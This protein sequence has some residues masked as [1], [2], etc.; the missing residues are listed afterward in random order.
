MAE[1]G[2]RTMPT[3]E[4]A[5]TIRSSFNLPARSEIVDD[6]G[7]PM[8]AAVSPEG[9][10]LFKAFTRKDVVQHMEDNL[11]RDRYVVHSGHPH[12]PER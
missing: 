5:R 4:S 3:P 6:N 8:F 1:N 11:P 12:W 10:I 7:K 2:T 9:Q